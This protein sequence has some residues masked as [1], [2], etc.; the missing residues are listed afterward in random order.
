MCSCF[1]V[2]VIAIVYTFDC[3][4]KFGVEKGGCNEGK[5]LERTSLKF[6]ASEA[7]QKGAL[8]VKW[9]WLLGGC[10]GGEPLKNWGTLDQEGINSLLEFNPYVVGYGKLM[11]RFS[12]EEGCCWLLWSG[13][14]S[15]CN[16][17][18]VPYKAE[19]SIWKLEEG[20]PWLVTVLSPELYCGLNLLWS[21]E[22]P[23]FTCLNSLLEDSAENIFSDL[24]WTCWDNSTPVSCWKFVLDEL[25]FSCNIDLKLF[26]VP[27]SPRLSP[28][29]KH[30]NNNNNKVTT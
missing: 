24:H 14:N 22:K 28:S 3:T 12:K 29:N 19:E 11:E 15:P 16:I 17:E 21:N 10:F 30:N 26:S 6:A 1:V 2:V 23:L 9:S 4:S 5:K 20:N 25:K 7:F 13:P 27:F 8:L 18:G